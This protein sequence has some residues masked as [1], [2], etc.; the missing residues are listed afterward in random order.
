MSR[1]RSR[2][3]TLVELLVV[4]AIIGILVALLLPAVQAAR[5]AARRMQCVNNMKQLGIALHNYHDTYKALPI[6]ANWLGTRLNRD[7]YS[8]FVVL[9]PFMEQQN[10]YEAAADLG[11]APWLFI[12]EAQNRPDLGS[13][14]STLIC[15][16]D[17]AARIPG[18]NAPKTNMVVCFGDAA[19]Q[20][21]RSS[22]QNTIDTPRNRGV[23][24]NAFWKDLSAITDGTSNTIAFGEAVT[25]NELRTR[26]VRGGTAVVSLNS[27]YTVSP[28][29]CMNARDPAN[30]AFLRGNMLNEGNAARGWMYGLHQ[31]IYT[32]FNTIL[33]PNSPNCAAVNSAAQWGIFSGSS[34]HPGG[35]N[36]GMVD[37]SVRFV[38]DNIDCGGLPSAVM[39]TTAQSANCDLVGPS[40][41]GVW[42][43]LGTPA[44]EESLSN[45]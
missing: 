6:N 45:W 28:M 13:N 25:A 2:A 1:H 3:F 44:G 22:S 20:N 33:P 24:T 11:A 26:R 40:P 35:M 38:T 7:V 10:V 4:I 41:F 39:G 19:L 15:P 23:F 36:V 30:T 37:G 16:S 34:N 29:N 17:G 8:A 12:W 32:T 5:E 42:G 27:G 43:A 21:N 31:P 18:P 14:V 9:L